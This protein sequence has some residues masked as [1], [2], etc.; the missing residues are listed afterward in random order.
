MKTSRKWRLLCSIGS[1]G[2]ESAC[3]EGDLGSIPGLERSPRGG[4]GS[5]LQYSYLENPHGQ[6][7][8]AGPNP[9]DHKELDTTERLST[10]LCSTE[11]QFGVNQTMIR[12]KAINTKQR[13]KKSCQS[14]WSLSE[15]NK[16]TLLETY[17]SGLFSALICSSKVRLS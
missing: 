13:I 14:V 9:W 15:I 10:A 1:D 6:R 8:L 5:P 3:S 4:H 17:G 2:K 7:S 11:I 12:G 16:G